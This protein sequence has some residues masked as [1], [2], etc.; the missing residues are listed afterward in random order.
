MWAGAAAHRHLLWVTRRF[1]RIRQ[2]SVADYGV[3]FRLIFLLGLQSL[4]RETVD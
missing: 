2:Q 1:D 3:L 4:P